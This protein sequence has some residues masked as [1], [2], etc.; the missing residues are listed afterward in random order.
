M[1]KALLILLAVL[2]VSGSVFAQAATET[3]TEG[4]A[5]LTYW[6]T[7]NAAITAN[8]F[9]ELPYWQELMA[10]T[11]TKITFQHVAAG[12]NVDEAFAVLTA[13]RR[14]MPDIIEYQWLKYAGGPQKALDDGVIIAL[15]DYL[16]YAPNLKKFL[17]THPDIAN[18]VKSEDG[19]YY[20]FPMLRGDKFEDNTLIY[21]EGWVYRTDLLAKAGVE[22]I[23]ETPDELYDALVK[24]K[25]SGLVEWPIAIRGDHINRVFGPGFDSWGENEGIYVDNG[26]VKSG[27]LEHNRYDYLVFLNKLYT[28]G[29]L[30]SDY[31]TLDKKGMGNLILNS[32]TAIGYA[33]GGSG[34]GTWLPQMQKNDPSVTMASAKPLSPEKGRLAKFA[35]MDTLYSNAGASAAITTSCKDIPAAMRLL[36]YQFGEDGHMLANFGIEGVSYKMENGEPVYL[37]EVLNENGV[38]DSTKAWKYMRSTVNGPFVFDTRMQEFYYAIPELKDALKLWAQTT[39]GEHDM[40]LITVAS[41]HADEYARIVNDVKQYAKEWENKFITG[42]TPLNEQTFA[43]YQAGLKGLKL[44]QAVAWRQEAYDAYISR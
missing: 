25:A 34:I 17:E 41:E 38:L 3:K 29:L 11:N 23:P 7:L 31:L 14:S 37:P 15:N 18:M 26:V 13:S 1:K 24:I 21:S 9:D 12:N 19:S 36:D 39:Y 33:P 27:L 16:D 44:E 32:T 10:M 6:A 5:E 28:E 43:E 8:S 35:K 20:C 4:P 2:L 40:T 22:A 42:A 30:Y